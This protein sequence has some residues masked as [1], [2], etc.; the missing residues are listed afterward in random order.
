[1]EFGR[2]AKRAELH[3]QEI[4]IANLAALTANLNRDSKK[5]RTPYAVKDFCF[6][7]PLEGQN[8]PEVA[9][10]NAFV[11]LLEEKALPNWCLFVYADM[12]KGDASA[13]PATPALIGEGVVLLAPVPRNGGVE[14]LMLARLDVADKNIE[15]TDGKAR[16]TVA[17]P[18]FDGSVIAREGVFLPVL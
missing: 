4:G 9:A 7:A 11:K 3:E 8:E 12:K 6:F 13:S 18:K 10:A 17:I 2:K 16:F 14:G 15:V 5:Q 1:M